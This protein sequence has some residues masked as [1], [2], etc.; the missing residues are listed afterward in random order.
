MR[1]QRP[2]LTFHDVAAMP[3][4]P[5][6]GGVSDPRKLLYEYRPWR[7]VRYL[8]QELGVEAI[9]LWTMVKRQRLATWRTID[10]PRYEGG[11][12]GYCTPNSVLEPLLVV[13]RSTGVDPAGPTRT[14][15]LRKRLVAIGTDGELLA[16]RRIFSTMSEAAESSIMEGASSTTRDA[17]ELLRS[18]RPPASLAEHMILNNYSA[19][20]QV[21]QWLDRDLSVEMLLELQAILANNAIDTPGGVGRLRVATEY[22]RVE[23]ARTAEVIFTPPPADALTDLLRAICAFANREHSGPEFIHPIVKSAILH[24]L[25]GYAHPFVDGNG[26]TARAVFYWNALRHG[27]GIFEFLSI[28]EIIRKGFARYPQAYVDTELDDGDLTYF[29]AYHLDVIQQALDR[30]ADH[31]EA[32]KAR[33]KQSERFLRIAKGLNLRQ[34]LLLEHALRHPLTQYTVK[35]HANSNGIV[36][37]TSRADLEE[38]VRLRLLT[39]A[40]KGKQVLYLASPNLERRLTRARRA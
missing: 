35:S 37:A 15:T 2:P 38:L 4:R 3:Q 24:F 26:R 18:G 9:E 40:K 33:V 1:D 27:Y 29:I 30:L 11:A 14:S 17:V 25:V 36:L 21:K 20:Q 7:K 31:I 10:V 19:M 8:A 32:E 34:R 22:V 28:S 16:R 5:A 13:D 12:F 6:P 23:D 39:T